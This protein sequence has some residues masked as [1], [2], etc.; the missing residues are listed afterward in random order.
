MENHAKYGDSIY[1]HDA[2]SLY[3]NLFIASELS[4]QEKEPALT[5]TT[6]FPEE[7]ADAARRPCDPSH[8]SGAEDSPS[9]MV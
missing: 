7:G 2:D 4:W 1:F 8:A 9:V 6:K 3:V 5:Q